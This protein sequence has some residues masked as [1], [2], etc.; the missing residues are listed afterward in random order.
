M[1]ARYQGVAKSAL[2]AACFIKTILN[3]LTAPVALSAYGLVGA[4]LSE[5]VTNYFIPN[6]IA[7]NHAKK[8]WN[9]AFTSH[10]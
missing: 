4:A 6:L 9:L 3:V 8:S 10:I 5:S 2:R 1:L 7:S